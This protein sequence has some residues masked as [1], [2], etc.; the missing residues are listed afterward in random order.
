MIPSWRCQHF[1]ANRWLAWTGDSR[2]GVD[3]SDAPYCGDEKLWRCML[4]NLKRSTIKSTPSDWYG[5]RLFP[6]GGIPEN[7]TDI[8]RHAKQGSLSR[9]ETAVL[10]GGEFPASIFD[11]GG[12]T[13]R[14]SLLWGTAQ[15]F[16]RRVSRA[17]SSMP[18]TLLKSKPTSKD[19]YAGEGL[20]LAMGILGRN[21]GLNPKQLTFISANLPPSYMEDTSTWEPRPAKVMRSCYTEVMEAQ[22]GGLG[23]AY[24]HA[25]VELSLILVD[26]PTEA[27]TAWLMAGLEHQCLSLNVEIRKMMGVKPHELDAHYRSSYASMILS[28]NYMTDWISQPLARPDLICTGILLMAE[29]KPKPEWWDISEM[30]RRRRQEDSLLGS[31]WRQAALCLLGMGKLQ[32]E[33]AGGQ[34]DIWCFDGVAIGDSGDDNPSA[35]TAMNGESTERLPK[36]IIAS[37][38]S[39][40]HRSLRPHVAKGPEFEEAHELDR[41]ALPQPHRMRLAGEN[42]VGRIP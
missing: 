19:G 35:T 8:L 10:E 34:D 28:L 25:A 31:G 32:V 37:F 13:T 20:C 18:A 9:K 2:T 29:N 22:Y 12:A 39:I 11:D 42:S 33:A 41:V 6:V 4:R 14:V 24:V 1:I 36:S 26:C 30:R 38:G 3:I 16:R 7:P 23:K 27:I 5:W 17:T 40:F 15:N 21:K